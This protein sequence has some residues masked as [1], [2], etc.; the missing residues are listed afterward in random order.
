MPGNLPSHPVAI[1]NHFVDIKK[2]LPFAGCVLRS[3]GL[4]CTASL[5]NF[6]IEKELGWPI[7]LDWT[8]ISRTQQQPAGD[9][10]KHFCCFEQGFQEFPILHHVR[11]NNVSR[12]WSQSWQPLKEWCDPPPQGELLLS[13]P[14]VLCLL[15]RFLAFRRW[16]LASSL[17]NKA[18][19]HIPNW[20]L[21]GKTHGPFAPVLLSVETVRQF[22]WLNE[23]QNNMQ[24]FYEKIYPWTTSMGFNSHEICEHMFS[25]IQGSLNGQSLLPCCQSCLAR[26]PEPAKIPVPHAQGWEI[27]T[28]SSSGQEN[29]LA[30]AFLHT[31]HT[32]TF[33]GES[34]HTFSVV[35]LFN[36]WSE[37]PPR[38]APL[39]R[40]G[41]PPWFQAGRVF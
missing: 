21:P 37:M 10:W 27:P 32:S 36:H 33:T 38:Q 5:I 39:E 31:C 12:Y 26:L 34:P 24:V 28:L 25:A 11:E 17:R 16:T 2:C 20:D 3:P 30:Q 23:A 18:K 19:G 14:V 4:E 13:F 29:F 8:G 1:T 22:L 40:R 35:L 41:S 9:Y 7:L 6:L 15:S